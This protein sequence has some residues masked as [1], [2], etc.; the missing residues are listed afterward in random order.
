[1]P[2]KYKINIDLKY[3]CT[4]DDLNSILIATAFSGDDNKLDFIKTSTKLL[5]SAVAALN[6]LFKRDSQLRNLEEL[7]WPEHSSV[8]LL[9]RLIEYYK[10]VNT[11]DSNASN[12]NY[13]LNNFE[14]VILE[15]QYSFTYYLRC[16][17]DLTPTL[18]DLLNKELE[19]NLDDIESDI[20]IRE[21]YR[22]A[23]EYFLEYP[24]YIDLIRLVNLFNVLIDIEG[25]HIAGVLYN[26]FINIKDIEHLYTYFPNNH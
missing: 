8:S 2:N 5:I 15:L 1:M 20:N 19:D 3:K 9:N 13:I 6:L 22:D 23:L 16:C 14:L 25:K 4:L 21:I 17:F 26:Y 18:S 10:E 12:Y 11:L 24:E 7:S